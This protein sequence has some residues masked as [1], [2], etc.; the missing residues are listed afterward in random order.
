MKNEEAWGSVKKFISSENRIVMDDYFKPEKT[1][2][3]IDWFQLKQFDF[4]KNPVLY[5][6]IKS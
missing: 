6:K 3:A 5:Q 1:S 4:R 2:E